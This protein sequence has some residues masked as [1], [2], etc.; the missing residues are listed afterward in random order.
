[1][2][3]HVGQLGVMESS[4]GGALVTPGRGAL[5]VAASMC[6]RRPIR[7][8]PS[9]KPATDFSVRALQFSR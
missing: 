1:M 3:A 2:F 9:K 6:G 7:K 5:G 8:I 4:D